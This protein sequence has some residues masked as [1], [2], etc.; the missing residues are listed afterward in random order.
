MCAG[1]NLGR[2]FPETF[3]GEAESDLNSLRDLFRR[4]GFIRRQELAI[5]ALADAGLTPGQI[6]ALRPADLEPVGDLFIVPGPGGPVAVPAGPL[7]GYFKRRSELG[8]DASPAGPLFVDLSG[9]PFTPEA[10]AAYLRRARLVRT[11]MEANA[12]VCWALLAARNPTGGGQN[13]PN[14]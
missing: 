2:S 5:R 14:G 9:R 12:F 11:S 13:V 4:K 1:V 10:L 8:L 7:R 6:C 3:P